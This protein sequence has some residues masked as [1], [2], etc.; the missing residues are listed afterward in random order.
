MAAVALEDLVWVDLL[1]SPQ[2]VMVTQHGPVQDNITGLFLLESVKCMVLSSV[3]AAAAVVAMVTLEMDL[4][5]A[6]VVDLH[7]E[8]LL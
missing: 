8:H 6:V 3:L 1:L 2:V 5:L 4:P 7:G